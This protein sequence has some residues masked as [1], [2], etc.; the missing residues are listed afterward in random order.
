MT[1]RRQYHE[2]DTSGFYKNLTTCY[3]ADDVDRTDR[4]HE[5]VTCPSDRIDSLTAAFRK[6]SKKRRRVRATSLCFGG[7]DG[8]SIAVSL[9]A[10]V[11][12]AKKPKEV[13]LHR[14]DL[15][16]IHATTNYFGTTTGEF[17]QP[18]T[19]T[20]KFVEYAGTKIVLTDSEIAEAKRSCGV[21]GIHVLGFRQPGEIARWAQ[22][23]RPARFMYP[24][25]ETK[26]KGATAAFTA[27]VEAMANKNRVAIAAYA[28][29]DD[30]NAGFRCC[31]LIPSVVPEAA[32]A[33]GPPLEGNFYVRREEEKE[34]E[35]GRGGTGGT[36]GTGGSG[37]W[38][39][40]GLHV[41]NL[42]F[43]DDVRHPE[44]AHATRK[45]TTTTTTTS[46]S[47]FF[48]T[49]ATEAQIA[50][51]CDTVDA[52]M[53]HEYNPLDVHNPTLRRHYRALESQA[54]DKEWRPESEDVGVGG[55]NGGDDLTLPPSRETLEEVGARAVVE[56]FKLAVYG[57][58]HD[59]EEEEDG[60]TGGG[61]GVKRKKS[62]AAAGGGG[63]GGGLGAAMTPLTDIDLR[64]L[65]A[66]G[67]LGTL[68]VSKLK[69]YCSANGL[70]TSGLKAALVARV[71]DHLLTPM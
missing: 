52:L 36:G 18:E 53:V 30:R 56:S 34:E 20:R 41:V 10:Q 28:R 24:E 66:A 70:S 59:A 7:G 57:A 38:T 29:A 49:T 60:R 58:N 23:N 61:G 19:M 11:S 21:D 62:A 2:F 1:A 43:L 32:A 48:S 63:G 37:G 14:R 46:S 6:K 40:N 55:N 68:T 25:E 12:E 31:A 51:A 64:A 27:L 16:E 26:Q 8:Q 9:Y 17:V 47:S 5:L 50:A 45:S 71:K 65:A 42:P 69:E 67:E 35:G 13:K 44:R 33:A 15:S 39:V 22:L 4:G 3:A 54:L